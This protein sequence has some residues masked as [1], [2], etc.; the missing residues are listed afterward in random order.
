[1]SVGSKFISLRSATSAITLAAF[2][3]V[4]IPP[5]SYA[6][7]QPATSLNIE[8][9]QD[10][11][12]PQVREQLQA[13]T[14][15]ALGEQIGQIDYAALVEKQWREVRMDVRLD[16]EIDEAI[17]I[18]REATTI[19]DR[20]YS[21]VSKD[22]AEKMAIA[23]AERA[24]GSEGF[25]SA[26]SDLAQGVSKDF[27]TRIEDAATRVSGPVIECVRTALQSRYGT[28]VADV[29]EKETQDNLNIAA[30]IG[31]ARIGSNDLLLENIGT[32]SGIVLIVSRRVIARVVTT[33]G[34]RIAGLVASRIVSSLTGLIGLALIAR[35][36]Y[37]ASEGVFPLIEERMKSDEAKTLIKTELAKS[38]EGDLTKQ[39][40]VIA[41]ETTE[42]IY[43]FWQ[44]FKQKY[45]VLLELAEK[46]PEFGAFLK[47]RKADELGRLGRIVSLIVADGG[48][49]AVLQKTRDG[50]LR[51][52]LAMLDEDGVTLAV[53][54]KS[55]GKAV[56]WAELAGPRLARVIRFRLPQVI[57]PEALNKKQLAALLSFDNA[58]AARRI[59]RLETNAREAL[60]SMPVEGMQRLARRLSETELDALSAYLGALDKG[61]ANFLLRELREN[62][63]LM[64]SLV[65]KGLRDA[66]IKSKDQLSAIRMLAR[67]N[68]VL[69][70]SDIRNDLSLV[71]K[72]DIHYRVFAERYW[73]GLLVAFFIGLLLLL[74]LRR[75]F[76]R[77]PATVIIKTDQP[78]RKT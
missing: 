36:L 31:N 52:A 21:T 68:S 40:D 43:A 76:F 6:Q 57:E 78:V 22:E 38:L 63:N 9:C 41:A 34:R 4:Q 1:M 13:L 55:L 56:K 16:R 19:L 14:R 53:E 74:T 44:D 11:G 54:L 69:N 5:A 24:Y 75:M 73:L 47:T 64:H 77:R 17:R 15:N 7:N 45:N 8:Q 72:G 29:F 26:I 50:S 18:E 60:L 70:I 27:G 12:D 39:V 20:A 48:E 10:L 46:H 30:E 25:R 49:Q 65:N 37:L 28:A 62:P 61:A 71:T 42:R 32:I 51:H 23:V 59:A 33:I 67:D 2:L 35:D 58:A 66:V 3:I